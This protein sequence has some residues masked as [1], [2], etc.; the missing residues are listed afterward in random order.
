MPPLQ[1]NDDPSLIVFAIR[2]LVLKAWRG[3][4]QATDFQVLNP[5]IT[6]L[7]EGF[8]R[9]AAQAYD[10]GGKDLDKSTPDNRR[11]LP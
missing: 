11:S 6:T 1:K 3:R 7:R 10:V 5:A 9:H 4:W 8:V 2:D